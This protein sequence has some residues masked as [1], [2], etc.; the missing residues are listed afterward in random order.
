MLQ[1]MPEDEAGSWNTCEGDEKTALVLKKAR[2]VSSKLMTKPTKMV[3]SWSMIGMWIENLG[4][5]MKM[6]SQKA[7]VW[8]SRLTKCPEMS[9]ILVLK[10]MPFEVQGCAGCA[11]PSN[12]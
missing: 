4:L 7:N 10:C 8:A 6:N 9:W 11:F 2:I 12:D 1:S 5:S 3:V